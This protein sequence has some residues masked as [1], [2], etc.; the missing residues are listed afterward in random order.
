MKR[1]LL[2]LLLTS[3]LFISGCWDRREIND[4]LMVVG[5]GMDLA[6]EAGEDRIV[7][8][9]QISESTASG[10]G[11][12]ERAAI[13]Q[14]FSRI[15]KP[16]FF[17]QDQVVVYGERLARYGLIPALDRGLRSREARRS[18]F[19]AVSRGEAKKVMETEMPGS[20]P[21]G[22]ALSSIFQLEGG[23][24]DIMP[25]TRNDFA[26]ALSTGV[27]SPVVPVV[28]VVPQSSVSAQDLK[29]PGA[30]LETL[31][32]S[33]LAVFSPD[34]KLLDFFNKEETMGLMLVRN[35]TKNRLVNVPSP[36]GGPEETV[37][38]ALVKSESKIKASIDETGLPSYEVKVSS[39][40]DVSEDFGNLKGMDE[41]EYFDKLALNAGIEIDKE[42]M[43]AVQKAQTLNADVFE[44]GEEL[45]RQ[46]KKEWPRYKEQ[47]KQVF[48]SVRV[49]VKCDTGMRHRGQTIKSPG[50]FKES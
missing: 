38:L 43:A 41:P 46:H 4:L 47:W 34:G 16:L 26:Y 29:T 31:K 21:S 5:I 20:Q 22:I 2:A 3:T 23:T 13:M 39:L 10:T 18:I 7:L 45:R 28:S 37:S 48:P 6:D 33:G 15:P 35:K 42:I 44:F 24:E 25:V 50:G 9:S 11:P 32:V 36:V 14:S 30:S 8:T 12:D 17:G 19:M 1:A 49:T 40:Y 27:T